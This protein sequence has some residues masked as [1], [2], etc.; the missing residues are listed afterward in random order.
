M[1]EKRWTEEQQNAI[2][3]REGTVLVSAAAGSGKTAVLVQRVIERITDDKNPCDADKLLVVTFTKA[4]ALEMRNRISQKISELIDKDPYNMHLRRQQILLTKAHISTIHSFCSEIVRENFYKLSISKEFR[5]A[6]THEMSILRDEALQHILLT[7]YE[8]EDKE[9]INFV[10]T[11]STGKDDSKLA[12]II[13][14]LYD[15]IRSHPF[16]ELWLNEK[17]SMYEESE[18]VLNTL[19]G[20]TILKYTN[21]AVNYCIDLTKGSL[22]AISEDNTI[23]DAYKDSFLSDL[24]SLTELE[25]IIFRGSWN[26]I[27]NRI[28]LFEFTKLKPLRGY[29]DDQIKN[30]VCGNRD[31]VKSTLKKLSKL[32]YSNEDRCLEDISKLRPIIRILFEAVSMFSKKLDELKLI[33]CAADFGDLE[34]WMIKLLVEPDGKGGYV[35]TETARI[36][37][38]KFEEVMV[39]E[40]QDTN[41]AQDIIFRA[42]SKDEGNLFLVG[43]VKQS[44]YRFRQAMPEIFLK[45]K[46]KYNKFAP[47]LKNYPAKI[48]LDKNFRSRREVTNTVN[49]VFRQIMSKQ[50]GQ[51]DY[52]DD[53]KLIPASSYTDNKNADTIVDIIDLSKSETTDMDIVEARHISKIIL[54]MI[55]E[56]YKI[57]D[58]DSERPVT[59]KDFCILMR[60]ANKHAAAYA[61]ELQLNSIPAWSDVSGSFFETTEISLILSLLK[62]INNPFN[63]IAILSVLLS[64]IFGFTPDKL[65]E[66]RLVDKNLP[67]YFAIKKLAETGDKECGDFICSIEDYRRLSLVMSPDKLIDY[68]YEKS[69]YSSMVQTME[70]GNLRLA[71]LRL[72]I[73]YAKNYGQSGYKSLLGFIRFINKLEQNRADIS[74]VSTVNENANA[75]KIMSIHR[76]KGLE[77][78]ICIIAGCSRKFNIDRDEILIHPSLG[79][80]IKLRNNDNIVQYA[81]MPREAVSIEIDNDNISEELRILYVAMTRAK[82]KLIL[83]NSVKDIDK[84]LKKLSSRLTNTNIMPAYIVRNGSSFSD[85]IISCALRHPSGSQLRKVA[86][87]VHGITVKDDNIWDIR[88]IYENYDCELYEE[89]V[90]KD[91]VIFDE[92]LIEEIDKRFNFVY[93]KEN[94]KKIP[95]KVSASIISSRRRFDKSLKRPGFIKKKGL[96]LK[97]KGI[98]LHNFMQFADYKCAVLNPDEEL[99]RLVNQ[100]FITKQQSDAINI[101]KIYEFFNSS[102]AKRILESDKIIREFRFTVDI[103]AKRI[104]DNLVGDENNESIILQG[105]VDCVFLEKD[106]IVIVDYKTGLS[107]NDE[108]KEAYADQLKLY[109]YAM[110]KCMNRRVKE[111]VIYSFAEGKVTV[112]D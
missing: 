30:K 1:I 94:L 110:E 89:S 28:N 101:S 47:Q 76:S 57:E 66:I 21:S 18:D 82:E 24:S 19:W 41:E 95:N 85:W 45:R 75:V 100:G 97:E 17:A 46:E 48:V 104:C 92:N 3:S 12:S 79:L 15:F 111:C 69:G 65:S 74:Q 60:S 88:L 29:K 23:E 68:I 16:P 27:S 63:D 33:K 102:L 93:S 106:E 73:E 39:D 58:G 2:N 38:E 22:F 49:F 56:G 54:K 8:R 77:F 42:L 7:F 67:L 13:N 91:E 25:N 81:T 70:N 103:P 84:T 83:I 34:H 98:A 32:F 61:H 31:E 105:A 10:E 37:S 52:N 59:Y 20:Q 43:D 14:T 99:K 62:I 64:P 6:D 72:L 40:Y 96:S 87:D 9:F 107:V 109:K 112:I 78:P 53:E 51:I 44:I 11:F 90:S 108:V 36:L 86:G 50:V 55:S 35:K 4:A 26:D 5:I 80:G 71:N